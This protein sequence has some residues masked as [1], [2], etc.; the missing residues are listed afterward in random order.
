MVAPQV[1]PATP[2]EWLTQPLYRRR[3]PTRKTAPPTTQNPA[4][5][6]R[7][8]RIRVP[9]WIEYWNAIE[10]GENAA[11]QSALNALCR[12][13]FAIARD[14][15]WFLHGDETWQSAVVDAL[16][17][18]RELPE[19]RTSF[20]TV[21]KRRMI[22]KIRHTSHL[23]LHGLDVGQAP[24]PRTQDGVPIESYD[25][26][27]NSDIWFDPSQSIYEDD[28]TVEYENFLLQV[29]AVATRLLGLLREGYNW[30][31]AGKEVGLSPDAARKRLSR[32]IKKVD[33]L[34]ARKAIH[35]KYERG[36][37]LLFPSP[38]EL[39]K[40]RL[41]YVAACITERRWHERQHGKPYIAHLADVSASRYGRRPGKNIDSAKW[42][43]IKARL[44]QAEADSGIVW[45][46]VEEQTAPNASTGNELQEPQNS[47]LFLPSHCE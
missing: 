41:E 46:P 2:G 45:A 33:G 15:H 21:L 37:D 47:C 43:E 5:A 30:S 23:S 35:V 24:Q 26:I 22:D 8:P 19:P 14:K 36:S 12:A 9:A 32:A 10:S 40:M 44:A 3:T 27:E 17:D 29:D 7:E 25:A 34:I 11:V 18:W 31:E 13:A 6:K 42:A 4:P 16:L 1:V 20:W 39:A 28:E 38:E